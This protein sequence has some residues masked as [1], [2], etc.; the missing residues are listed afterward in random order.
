MVP[1]MPPEPH[2]QIDDLIAQLCLEAG[3]VMEDASVELA[4]TLPANRRRRTARLDRL[5][6]AA[7]DIVALAG[8]AQALHRP[9]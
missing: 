4:L 2:F 1:P 3:R 9:R 5:S 7:A 6:Q 8:A